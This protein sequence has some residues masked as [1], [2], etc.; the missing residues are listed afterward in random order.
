MVHRVLEIPAAFRLT[1]LLNPFTTG[2]YRRLLREHAPQDPHALLLDLGCGLGDY[3]DMVECRALGVDVNPAYM[4]KAAEHHGP[5]FAAATAMD[6]PF[7]SETF[8][9]VL[10][11]ATC[12]HLS[13]EQVL[14][15]LEECFQVLKPHGYVL[16]IDPV[17]PSPLW[18]WKWALFKLD[19]GKH[20]R[21]FAQLKAVAGEHYR[22]EASP[23]VRGLLHDVVA[24]RITR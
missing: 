4:A 19:R 11:M 3:L 23:V 24:L 9:A 6:L 7:Q 10:I 15:A 2:I 1:Q 16:I 17:L 14:S 22:V 20:L 21:T 13:N 8:D 12:H 5:R 18:F